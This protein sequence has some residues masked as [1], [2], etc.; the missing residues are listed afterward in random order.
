MCR[1]EPSFDIDLARVRAVCD[2]QF[3]KGAA[4]LL[5]DGR[6][7]IKK[8]E[9]TGKIRNVLVD[10]EHILSMRANDGFFTLRPPGAVRLK[11]GFAPPLLRVTVKDDSIPFNREGKNVFSAFVTECDPEV[12]PMDEV[13]VVDKN[14]ELI[15]LGRALLTRDEMFSFRTGIAVKVREGIKL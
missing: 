9:T 13:L 8:S 3:G 10:G 14:D 12:R 7:L 4:D 6:V 5:L 11:K 2:Y 15:A 1:R